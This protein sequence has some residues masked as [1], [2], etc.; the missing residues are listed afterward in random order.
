MALGK[1]SQSWW[2]A[3][4]EDLDPP[5][6]HCAFLGGGV[7]WGTGHPL[8]LAQSWIGILPK[9]CLPSPRKASGVLEARQLAMRIFEDYTVSWYWIIM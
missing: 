8:E 4:S 9:P 7:G 6:Q 5:R 2:K 3:P 1:T